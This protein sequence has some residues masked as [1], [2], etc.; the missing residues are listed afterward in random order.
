[1]LYCCEESFMHNSALKNPGRRSFLAV[2]PLAA[3]AGLALANGNLVS[4]DAQQ[5]SGVWFVPNAFQMFSAEDLAA[6]CRAA[7]ATGTASLINNKNFTIGITYENAKS[8]AEFEWHAGRDHILHI[9]E[10]ETVYEVGGTPLNP[11]NVK[12]GEWLAP[13]REGGAHIPMKKGDM[14]V[15]PRG[16]LHRRLTAGSVTL[17]LIAPMGAA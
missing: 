9:L 7:Q 2:A 15:L 10:G 8:A 17:M 1:M 4:A 13:A 6:A 11:R 5:P 14:L 12:P 16:T 3:A